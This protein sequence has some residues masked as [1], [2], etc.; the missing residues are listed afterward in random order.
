MKGPPGLGGLECA[1]REDPHTLVSSTVGLHRPLSVAGLLL[2][3]TVGAP[4]C[5]TAVNALS[6]LELF[7]QAGSGAVKEGFLEEVTSELHLENGRKLLGIEKPLRVVLPVAGGL[8]LSWRQG[9]PEDDP[10]KVV[11]GVRCRF[12]GVPSPS[13]WPA[14]WASCRPW[15]FC[16]VRST[17][18]DTL[19][20]LGHPGSWLPRT[21]HM[22]IP[23]GSLA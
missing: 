21:S 1:C 10:K 5:H 11:A 13:S 12:R 17:L 6:A 2:S 15:G 20:V 18:G 9:E 23:K 22:F 8:V 19:G 7:P 16:L 3:G 4:C 14:T